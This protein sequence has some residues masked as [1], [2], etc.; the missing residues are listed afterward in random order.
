MPPCAGTKTFKEPS[1]VEMNKFTWV[2][3]SATNYKIFFKGGL[4][5][6][7]KSNIIKM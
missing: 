7:P 1:R 4:L 6:I 2:S 5:G 3:K